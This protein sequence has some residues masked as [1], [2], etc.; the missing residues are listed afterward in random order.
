MNWCGRSL[1]DTPVKY[2]LCLT[3]ADFDKAMR[4][5]GLSSVPFMDKGDAAVTHCLPVKDGMVAIICTKRS[6]KS[7][8]EAHALLVHEAVHVWQ[9]IK[10]YIGEKNS[11]DE[12]ESYCIQRI[13]LN[14]FKSYAK[15]RGTER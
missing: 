10:G 3:Q 13:S 2:G 7:I 14:L 8:E 9:L 4:E 11:G 5:L 12:A 6:K 15:Q 1:L